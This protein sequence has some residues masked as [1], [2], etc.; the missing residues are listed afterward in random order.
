MMEWKGEALA[1][2]CPRVP[3]R[4]QSLV[5]FKSRQNQGRPL[6][7]AKLPKLFSLDAWLERRGIFAEVRPGLGCVNPGYEAFRCRSAFF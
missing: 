7:L 6:R 3:S 2:R 1:G 5:E 4:S